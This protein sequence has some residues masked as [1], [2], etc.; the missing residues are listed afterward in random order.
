MNNN[1]DPRDK[2]RVTFTYDDIHRA[3]EV[4]ALKTLVFAIIR[5]LPHDV[6]INTIK[7]LQDNTD[8]VI[9]NNLCMEMTDAMI[10][11][12]KLVTEH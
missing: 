4:I 11:T 1:Q 6:A 8:D 2:A 3:D 10:A 5:N 9:L 7:T 12:T